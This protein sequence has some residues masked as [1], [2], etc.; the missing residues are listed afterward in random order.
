MKVVELTEAMERYTKYCTEGKGSAAWQN[1][2]MD[3]Y[4]LLLKGPKSNEE[5]P[6]GF[7]EYWSKVAAGTSD[8]YDPISGAL[9]GFRWI[10]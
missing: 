1:Y 2:I 5:A 8:L 9:R 3:V 4:T 7:V 10:K 6:P